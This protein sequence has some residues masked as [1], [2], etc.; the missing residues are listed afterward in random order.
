ML[1]LCLQALTT[2]LKS[3]QKPMA[4]YLPQILPCIWNIFTQSAEL[5]PSF[6]VSVYGSISIRQ[7]LFLTLK[8]NTHSLGQWSLQPRSEKKKDSV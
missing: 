6:H 2:I 3:F 5:Y 1:L 4:G 8:Q 7:V